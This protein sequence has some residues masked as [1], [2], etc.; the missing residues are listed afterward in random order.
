MALQIERNILRERLVTYLA[1]AFA[2]L[3][4]LLGC[5]GLYGVLSY[6]VARRTQEFGVR[7][8]L[9]ASPSDLTRDV[10]GDALRVAVAGTAT[11]LVVALWI[12]GLLEA[13]L[14]EVTTVD[15][16]VAF[17]STALLMAATLAASYIPARRAA[18]VNPIAA[19]KTD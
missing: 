16:G 9:G 5:V 15:P 11:G 1:A 8:A 12:S 2:T 4:L 19:L 3:S 13:L 10:F 6:S 14:F 17:A 7:L 18:R